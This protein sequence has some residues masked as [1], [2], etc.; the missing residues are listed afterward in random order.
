MALRL[1]GEETSGGGGAPTGASYVTTAAEAGLSAEKVLGTDVIMSGTLAARPAAATAG[2]LYFAT[3][4][5]GGTLYRDTGAAWVKLTAGLTEVLADAV[6]PAGVMRD[7]EHAADAHAQALTGPITRLRTGTD[8]AK[9]G[10]GNTE[11]DVWWATDTNKLYVWDAA[12]WAQVHPSSGGAHQ[13]SRVVRTAGDYTTTS[14]VFVD[15]DTAN[16][17]I[18]LTITAGRWVRLLLQ[19]SGGGLTANFLTCFDFTVG[20]TRQGQ[21]NGIIMRDAGAG[22]E[23][24]TWMHMEWLY[25]ETVGG[26]ITF[27]P[28]WKVTGGTGV[29]RAGTAQT[30]LL[31]SVEEIPV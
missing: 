8:A 4:D 1:V 29:I 18:T 25:Q 27:R 19:G 20:G 7:A 23:P 2:R 3:D 17:A 6:V 5:A 13:L 9:P 22:P 28:Q 12:A 14:T 21:T 24:E 31:F 10:G 16:L 26:S 15:I 11:G 30:P